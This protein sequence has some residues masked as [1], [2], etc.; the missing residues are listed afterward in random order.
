MVESTLT[1]QSL[2][3]LS[4]HRLPDDGA[5]IILEPVVQHS[6]GFVKHEV[7]NAT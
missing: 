6:V 1:H 2:T 3:T 4:G 5:N 7:R